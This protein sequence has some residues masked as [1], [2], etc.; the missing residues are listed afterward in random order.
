LPRDIC[1]R[2]TTSHFD[3]ARTAVEVAETRIMT[4]RS[5]SEEIDK[6][7]A[8]AQRDAIKANQFAADTIGRALTAAAKAGTVFHRV[9]ISFVRSRIDRRK[10]KDRASIRFRGTMTGAAGAHDAHYLLP[11]WL[12]CPGV[13]YLLPGFRLWLDCHPPLFMGAGR[14]LSRNCSTAPGAEFVPDEGA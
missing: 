8:A 11:L 12:I 6:V 2:N 3:E 5:T 4:V 1:R 9:K 10:L 7:A 14:R 13:T